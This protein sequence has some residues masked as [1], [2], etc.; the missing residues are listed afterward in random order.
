MD[1]II[2]T[3]TCSFQKPEPWQPFQ[4]W[5]MPDVPGPEKCMPEEE[6]ILQATE[7]KSI[8]QHTK[9]A[10][11]YRMFSAVSNWCVQVADGDSHAIG[12]SNESDCRQTC[13]RARCRSGRNRSI[14]VVDESKGYTKI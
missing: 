10:E 7:S 14:Y 1:N 9:V 12:K 5:P 11:A 4:Q 6:R 8:Q 3:M 2:L 13:E